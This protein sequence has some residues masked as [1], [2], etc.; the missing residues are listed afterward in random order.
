MS[1][2]GRTLTRPNAHIKLSSPPRVR[3]IHTKLCKHNSQRAKLRQISTNRITPIN[4][5]IEGSR[6]NVETMGCGVLQKR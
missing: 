1:P 2:P 3:H 6:E 4:P 5:L